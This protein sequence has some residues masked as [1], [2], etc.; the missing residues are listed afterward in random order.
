MRKSST[1]AAV[2]LTLA[3]GGA[4]LAADQSASRTPQDGSPSFV[5]SEGTASTGSIEDALSLKPS[6][7][8][9]AAQNLDRTVAWYRNFLG[10]RE[11]SSRSDAQWRVA[12]LERNGTLLEVCEGSQKVLKS[13]G[14]QPATSRPVSLEMWV[15]DVDHEAHRLQERGI[16]LV[17]RPRD[18]LDGEFRGVLIHDIDGRLIGLREPLPSH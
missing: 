2:L 16:E 7:A 3:M 8:V 6:S 4:G 9:I 5:A 12:F 11:I 17:T 10:F 14:G 1:V 15:D 18:R 13:D